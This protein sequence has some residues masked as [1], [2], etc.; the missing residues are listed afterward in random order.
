MAAPAEDSANAQN[1][2]RANAN[3]V[4]RSSQLKTISAS[5]PWSPKSSFAPW[6]RYVYTT[7][8]I[9]VRRATERPNSLP[10]IPS[11]TRALRR[12]SHEAV[13]YASD[14]LDVI[15]SPAELLAQPFHVR[16][17]GARRDVG[18]DSPHIVEKRRSTLDPIPAIPEGDEQ[19]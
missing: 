12:G 10:R 18:A 16:I 1:T 3:T 2:E 19:L 6:W 9:A 11:F 4:A 15:P 14:G 13:A 7:R 8:K 5:A 17:H